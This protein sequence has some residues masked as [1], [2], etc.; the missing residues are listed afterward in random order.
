M[1]NMYF[2]FITL[3]VAGVFFAGENCKKNMRVATANATQFDGPY[4]LYKEDK[5]IV[6]YVMEEDGWKIMK[7]DT[8]DLLKKSTTAI[9]VA[10]DEP[11]ITFPVL[12]KA[13]LENEASEYNDVAKQFVV[14]DIEGNFRFFR[15][16]LQGNGIIDSNYNW[17][18]GN[19]HLVLT[20]DFFDRGNQVTEA[21]WLIYSLEEKAKAAG[22]YVHF[23]LGNHE[24]MN[25]N[26]DL[27]YL[28]PK[29]RE[30]AML[31]GEKYEYL[32]SEYSELGRWL[33]TKN[34][35]EK[36]GDILYAHAGISSQMNKMNVTL[37]TVNDLA[38][39]WYPD[40]SFK[41]TDLRVDTIFSDAGPFWYRGYYK[42]PSP[43]VMQQIDSTIQKFGVKYIATGHT[44]VADTISV[45]YN[46]KLFN[47]DVHH[48]AG[49]SE[50]LL[51]EDG[52]FFRVNI[53]GEKFL[54]KE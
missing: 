13:A 7:S 35:M 43:T 3:I 6:R 46:G 4:V 29:Y 44:V 9:S 54:I 20:G 23:V 25:M 50:G 42:T 34:I 10:T 33:R 22:G 51:I 48:A 24:I 40:S 16:L 18:F 2:S 41:Y 26:G 8:V 49:K 17:T 15:K 19:G 1:K 53:F 39:P 12:L 14:S 30:T 37:Q 21:L 11:G 38:R 47:T 52:K 36:V 32:F 5:M 45:R 31:L 28:H 27:R